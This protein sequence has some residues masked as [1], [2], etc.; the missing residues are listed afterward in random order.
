MTGIYI[1]DAYVFEY[2]SQCGMSGRGEYEISDVNNLY[3]SSGGATF[4]ECAGWWTDAG[5]H[6][7]YQNAN[8]LITKE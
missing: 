4:V 2:V 6:D 1:Y 3:V 7:S 5:T 8:R